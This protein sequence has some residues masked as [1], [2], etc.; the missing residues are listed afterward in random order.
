[1]GQADR[2]GTRSFVDVD[3]L[4]V[5]GVIVCG[6]LLAIAAGVAHGPRLAPSLGIGRQGRRVG[7]VNLLVL[8]AVEYF[9]A[10]TLGW[11]TVTLP[12]G[13]PPRG[14]VVLIVL[15]PLVIVVAATLAVRRARTADRGAG[16]ASLGDGTPDACW[17]WG[18]VYVN[19]AD[20]AL[21][22]A[23]RFGIGYTLNFGHPWAW[24]V[25]VL[26]LSPVA[27][28]LLLLVFRPAA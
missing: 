1:M 9:L 11:F 3:G 18:T 26:L 19:P 14:G 17:K 22:V 6:L 21:F 13:R 5:L 23:K 12:F 27:V 24:P 7:R 8:L 10:A 20:P 25:L 15:A 4:A 2:W 28:L 16:A